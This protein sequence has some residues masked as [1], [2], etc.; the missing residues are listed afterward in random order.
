MSKNNLFVNASNMHQG[1]GKILLNAF[2]SG[3]LDLNWNY[4]VF[5]DKRYK[6]MN[7][8]SNNIN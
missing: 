6:P 7:N 8:L 1:G 2:L 4:I 3:L 5:I